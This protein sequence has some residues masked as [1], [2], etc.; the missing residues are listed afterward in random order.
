MKTAK[1]NK[2]RERKRL[3]QYDFQM[4][5]IICTRFFAALRMTKFQLIQMP[6][7]QRKVLKTAKRNKQRE[8][9]KAKAIRF[10][11]VYDNMY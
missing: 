2:Q 3:R 9:K 8:R 10:P 6:I 4:Y 5:T 11:N 1:I 7:H